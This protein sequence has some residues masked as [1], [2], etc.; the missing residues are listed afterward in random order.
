MD[1]VVE[2]MD[3]RSIQNEEEDPMHSSTY[4]A[5]LLQVK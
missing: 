3:H 2:H 4:A 1:A 5:L